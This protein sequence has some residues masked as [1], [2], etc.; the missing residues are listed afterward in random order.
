M[1]KENNNTEITRKDAIKKMG[2]Y[3]AFTAIGTFA[4]LNPLSAQNT[5]K[6][7]DPNARVNNSNNEVIG[8]DTSGSTITTPE[9]Q[10]GT[11]QVKSN[12]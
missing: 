4:V 5:S 9:S 12:F 3:A 2:K 8:T 1:K 11:S 6:P 10:V 7:V